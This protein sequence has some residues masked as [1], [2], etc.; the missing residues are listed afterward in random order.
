MKVILAGYGINS[1]AMAILLSD[2]EKY[3]GLRVI[4]T[5]KCI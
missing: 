3:S 5:E 4:D 2:D 1:A